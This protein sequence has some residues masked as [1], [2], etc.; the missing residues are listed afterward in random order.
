MLAL[1]ASLLPLCALARRD[2]K[3]LRAQAAVGIAPH[4]LRARQALG[5]TVLLP[6][7]GLTVLGHWP[8]LLIW[9][10]GLTAAGWGLVQW[11]AARSQSTGSG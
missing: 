2:P 5:A 4:G 11:L 10:G 9:L 6:G 1:L 3:R 8:A 7:L